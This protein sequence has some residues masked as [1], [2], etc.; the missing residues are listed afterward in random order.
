MTR[1]L[2]NEV[3]ELRQDIGFGFQ[4][5]RPTENFCAHLILATV[6]LG[7][8]ANRFKKSQSLTERRKL[9]HEYDRQKKT[10][11]K[12]IQMLY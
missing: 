5:T 11:Q 9:I 12:G 8:I 4:R 6:Q 3:K 10:I 7:L 2:E 1:D